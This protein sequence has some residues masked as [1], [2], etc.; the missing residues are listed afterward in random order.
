MKMIYFDMDG[1]LVDLYGVED[2]LSKLRA[3][4]SSPYADAIPLLRFCTLAYYI[5]KLQKAGY[6]VGIISWLSKD[7]KVTIEYDEEV[8]LTKIDY[9]RRRLP[10]V[11]WDAIHITKP[12][13]PK[14]IF[15]KPGAILFDDEAE[16]RED[17]KAHGGTAYGVDN[18]LE[19]LRE[20]C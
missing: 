13:I 14:S 15:C 4:D 11:Q 20:L 6:E 1:T 16:N 7:P 17:W 8:T 10:S 18:I 19:I 2:W 3:F 12:N 9:L 5:H